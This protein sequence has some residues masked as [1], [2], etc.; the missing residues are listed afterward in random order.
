M[1][2]IL[3]FAATYTEVIRYAGKVGVK[4]S[5]VYSVF[6]RLSQPEALHGWQD[7]DFVIISRPYWLTDTMLANFEL[8]RNTRIKISKH[9][10]E[11][12]I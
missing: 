2:P 6:R 11:A 3:V 1:K 10:L 9:H 7:M 8:H 5:E 12:A 4:P